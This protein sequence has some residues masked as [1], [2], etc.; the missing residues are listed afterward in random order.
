MG[1]CPDYP[2][3]PLDSMGQTS[4]AFRHRMDD[5]NRPGVLVV[6][7]YLSGCIPIVKECPQGVLFFLGRYSGL[8]Q[9]G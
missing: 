2:L 9:P 4:S 5:R 1:A 6:A 7:I 8:V 3:E